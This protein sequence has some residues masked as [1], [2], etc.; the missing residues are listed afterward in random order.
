MSTSNA[1]I[2]SSTPQMAHYHHYLYINHN[3]SP[4]QTL[5]HVQILEK[6]R[7]FNHNLAEMS[8]MNAPAWQNFMDTI[9]DCSKHLKREENI[10]NVTAPKLS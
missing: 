9:R 8:N 4:Y 5:T 1:L 2:L 7:V 10:Y 3:S 6:S